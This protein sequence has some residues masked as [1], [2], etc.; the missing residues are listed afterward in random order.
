MVP[1]RCDEQVHCQN[2]EKEPYEISKADWREVWTF[3]KE[4]SAY[5]DKFI[6][7]LAQLKACEKDTLVW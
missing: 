1:E 4:Y 2:S 7:M 6:N 5:P 3:L